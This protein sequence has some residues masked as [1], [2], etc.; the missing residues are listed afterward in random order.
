MGSR[1][2][3]CILTRDLMPAIALKQR[4]DLSD[5]ERVLQNVERLTAF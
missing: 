3:S 5:C 1:Q 4:P 2:D